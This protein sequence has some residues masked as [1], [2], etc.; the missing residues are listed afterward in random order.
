MTDPAL[1]L[2]LAT[3]IFDA[4]HLMVWNPLAKVPGRSLDQIYAGLAA[5]NEAQFVPPFLVGWIV[6]W[7]LPALSSRCCAEPSASP[8][9]SPSCSDC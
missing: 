5:A 3:V 8:S 1:G 2:I 9:A 6:F 7:S 4:L